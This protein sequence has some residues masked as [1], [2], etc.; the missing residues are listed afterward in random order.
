MNI[1]MKIINN[2]DEWEKYLATWSQANFLQSW[3]WGQFHQSLGKKVYYWHVIDGAQI[4]GCALVVSEKA[5]RGNYLTI[6]GGPLL[7]WSS[8]NIEKMISALRKQLQIIAETERAVFLRVRLQEVESDQLHRLLRKQGFQLAPM[9][10]TADLTLELDL[11]RSEDE[12]LKEMRK[13]TRYEIHKADKLGITTRL[14]RDPAEV[15]DF[16]NHQLEVAQRQN[17]VP[18]SFDFLQKQFEAFLADDQVLLIHSYQGEQL[19]ASAFVIL[20][21]NEAVYHYGISTEQNAKLPGSYACQWAAIREAKR[22]GMKRYNFWG[23]G[24]ANDKHH[25]FAGVGL[26][27]RGFGGTEVQYL[28]AY[29]L[30]FSWHYWPI[31]FFELLRKKMRRL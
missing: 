8:P 27:K 5:K 23:I 1:T 24:P 9:H 25:R 22:R 20:Y 10:L 6:A 16:Y 18:F 15:Q 11:S 12:L 30:A 7:D 31:Y 4:I 19:L 21:G 3:N 28:P 13:N 26:F 29:D 14:S 2:Q 17:F